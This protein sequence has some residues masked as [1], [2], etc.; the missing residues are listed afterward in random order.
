MRA[1]SCALSSS[2]V[3]LFLAR[4]RAQDPAA[5]PEKEKPASAPN[6][7]KIVKPECNFV[8]SP[9]FTEGQR[10]KGKINYII[11]HTVE[12]SAKGCVDWFLTPKS[13]VSAHYVVAKDGKITQM[14]EDKDL[15]WHAGVHLYNQEAI[16]IEH[17]GFAAKNLWTEAQVRASAQLSRWLCHTY[18]IPV[19]RKHLLGHCEIA[20]GRKTDPGPYFDWDLYLKLIKDPNAKIERRQASGSEPHQASGSEPHQASGSEPR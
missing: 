10:A 9:N 6:S 18:E 14:V 1:L 16:G 7:T 8:R 15:A 19:D 2:L 13:K 3:V 5:S 4:A 20:P 12:G 11:I 17:E